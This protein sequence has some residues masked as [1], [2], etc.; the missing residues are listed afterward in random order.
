MF[1]GASVLVLPS[2]FHETFNFLAAES[3]QVGVPVVALGGAG[4]LGRF[5]SWQAPDLDALTE[6]LLAEPGTPSPRP[7]AEAGWA[8]IARRYAT[9]IAELP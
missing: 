2:R 9:V 7:R 8:E 4:E 6:R 3:V 1:A 5:A